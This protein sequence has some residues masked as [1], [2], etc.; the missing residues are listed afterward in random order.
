MLAKGHD[1][2]H[3]RIYRQVFSQRS[4]CQPYKRFC[5]NVSLWVS[6]MKVNF[7]YFVTK[8][9]TSE[10]QNW[11]VKLNSFGI[12]I[13]CSAGAVTQVIGI[14]SHCAKGQIQTRNLIF[15]VHYTNLRSYINAICLG[16]VNVIWWALLKEKGDRVRVTGMFKITVSELRYT[17][18]IQ[19][20]YTERIKH[21]YAL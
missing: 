10:I 19:D 3:D 2:I 14:A 20:T 18:F 9:E 15:F 4:N 17:D 12:T 21:F 5:N 6:I 13:W 8:L 7:R 1:R 16:Y 11:S